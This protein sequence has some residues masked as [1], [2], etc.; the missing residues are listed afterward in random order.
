MS[1]LK[2]SQ[3]SGCQFGTGPHDLSKYLRPYWSGSKN[4]PKQFSS[5]KHV[6]TN[7]VE[8]NVDPDQLASLEH[9]PVQHV[10]GYELSFS[11]GAYSSYFIFAGYLNMS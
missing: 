7:R 6:F 2:Y 10:K 4:C 3:L 9:T 5:N 11:A 1:R 8:Y